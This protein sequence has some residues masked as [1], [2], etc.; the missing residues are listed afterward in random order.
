MN[1]PTLSR[2]ACR[3][4]H[5]DNRYHDGRCGECARLASNAR[6]ARIRAGTPHPGRATKS[7]WTAERTA[8]L[9]AMAGAGRLVA[10][11]CAALGITSGQYR[12]KRATM[13]RAAAP[14]RSAPP[15]CNLRPVQLPIEPDRRNWQPLPA[16]HVDA[17]AALGCVSWASIECA[18]C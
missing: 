18:S 11:T 15:P 4:C 1:L 10:D 17:M 7:G 6:N 5:T 8:T 3:T 16:F 9:V 13:K 2:S 12:S 14:R